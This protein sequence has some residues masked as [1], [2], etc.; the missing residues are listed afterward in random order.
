MWRQKGSKGENTGGGQ[1]YL[2]NQKA[3][4]SIL[5]EASAALLMQN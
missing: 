4:I 5:V 3:E 2:P 1:R